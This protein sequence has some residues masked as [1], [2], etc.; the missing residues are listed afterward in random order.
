MRRVRI[1]ATDPLFHLLKDQGVNY[2]PETGQTVREATT[3]VIEFPVKAPDRAIT[4]DGLTT[5]ELLEYWMRVKI[6][7]TEH[8]P[9]MTV[10]IGEDEWIYASL[11]I[12]RNW[13]A[14]GGLSFLPRTDH[15]YQLAPFEAITEARYNKLV[16]EMPKI[17]FSKI[18][19]YEQEDNTAGAGELGC[20]GNLCEFS[21]EDLTNV[22]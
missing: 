22:P 14:I 7:Y 18:S 12:Y 17:D 9:S 2:S 19:D 20:I 1:S 11:W 15:V 5:K 13:E 8:N 6:N 4:T 21:P 10:Y 16:K 3:F